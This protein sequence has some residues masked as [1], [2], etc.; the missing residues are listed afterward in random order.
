MTQ[1]EIMFMAMKSGCPKENA[2][3]NMDI[4]EAFAKLVEAKERETCAKLVEPS[5]DHRANP[6]DYI[7]E[8]QGIELLDGIA[9]KIRARGEA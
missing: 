5:A 3:A 9:A 6:N 8:E 7:A 4:L 1:D 2:L